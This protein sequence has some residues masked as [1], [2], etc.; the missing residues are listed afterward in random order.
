MLRSS[1]FS[2]RMDTMC[3]TNFFKLAACHAPPRLQDEAQ[4]ACQPPKLVPR[5]SPTHGAPGQLEPQQFDGVVLHLVSV[6]HDAALL[7]G[8]QHVREHLF[9][10]ARIKPDSGH[11]I[12]VAH[13]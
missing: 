2:S 3:P 13:F 1:L 5:W 10:W 11:V 12:D 4:G 8:A 9:A 6:R 7:E